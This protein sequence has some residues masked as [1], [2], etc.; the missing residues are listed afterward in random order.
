MLYSRE[1]Y[2]VLD[3]LGDVGGLFDALKIIG[4]ALASAFGPGGLKLALI[5]KIFYQAPKAECFIQKPA[6]PE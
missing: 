6:S 2:N 1:I 3:F 5:G 4:Y